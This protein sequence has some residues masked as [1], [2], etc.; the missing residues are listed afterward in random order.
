M[1]WEERKASLQER[2]RG[3]RGPDGDAGQKD[4]DKLNDL[5]FASMYANLGS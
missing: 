5:E 2:G 1:N 4:F 3:K